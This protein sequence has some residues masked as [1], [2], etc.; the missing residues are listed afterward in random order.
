MSCKGIYWLL[1]YS[2]SWSVRH[3]PRRYIAMH[4]HHLRI[5]KVCCLLFNGRRTSHNSRKLIIT[6]LLEHLKHPAT[7]SGSPDDKLSPSQRLW[8]QTSDCLE[9]GRDGQVFI[10]YDP[11]KGWEIGDGV[12]RCNIGAAS[13]KYSSSSLQ[14]AQVAAVW[15]RL[16][17]D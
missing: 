14:P 1:R 15:P 10:V 17:R 2:Q 5:K 6:R 12:M 7:A 9:A 13:I 8:H 11:L 16:E 4:C 3:W